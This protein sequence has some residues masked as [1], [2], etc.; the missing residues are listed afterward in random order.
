[1][2]NELSYLSTRTVKVWAR[3][4]ALGFLLSYDCLVSHKLDEF[5]PR[6]ENYAPKTG[7]KK[8]PNT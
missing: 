4:M 7:K 8:W 1:M 5:N 2:G 3:P 6:L